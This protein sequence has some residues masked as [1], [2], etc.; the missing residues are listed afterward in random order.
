MKRIL[1]VVS[2]T[3]RLLRANRLQFTW[4]RL[5]AWI[6]MT[7]VWPYRYNHLV[8]HEF[9]HAVFF[10]KD[11]M[12]C[13]LHW[14]NWGNWP[15][16]TTENGL[17]TGLAL[18]SHLNATR[19]TARDWQCRFT[20]AGSFLVGTWAP[21]N[22]SW[23][24]SFPAMYSQ[25]WSKIARMDCRLAGDKEDTGRYHHFPVCCTGPITTNRTVDYSTQ[26]ASKRDWIHE[27]NHIRH[28]IVDLARPITNDKPASFLNI[29]TSQHSKRTNGTNIGPSK[30]RS[31]SSVDFNC[32][33][34]DWLGTE[35]SGQVCRSWKHI[36]LCSWPVEGQ[37]RVYN[38]CYSIIV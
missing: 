27:P 4:E 23:C 9:A 26:S 29:T 21:T 1:N 34:H 13:T 31:V 25:S 37:L 19:T 20:S 12:D 17:S 6:N 14:G 18:Y 22:R 35:E 28:N 16:N 10:I 2:L 36:R 8:N 7:E 5:A 33:R 38:V 11:V 3:G 24:D 32:R 15:K 30:C